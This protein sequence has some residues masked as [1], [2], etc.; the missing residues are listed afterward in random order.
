MKL[1]Y[2]SCGGG[3]WRAILLSGNSLAPSVE[4]ERKC[5]VLGLGDKLNSAIRLFSILTPTNVSFAD[6]ECLSVEKDKGVRPGS[7]FLLF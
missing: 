5:L 1:L 6:A 2:L 3:S 4:S 7:K